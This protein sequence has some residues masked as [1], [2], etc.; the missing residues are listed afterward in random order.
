MPKTGRFADHI[1]Q[2]RIPGVTAPLDTSG[3]TD[4]RIDEDIETASAY[5]R[6]TADLGPDTIEEPSDDAITEESV[7]SQDIPIEDLN[8]DTV[9]GTPLNDGHKDPADNLE[10]PNHIPEQVKG[11]DNS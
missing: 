4:I 5:A 2:V 10:N 8:K 7:H 3:T 9:S 11:E 6:N 1:S